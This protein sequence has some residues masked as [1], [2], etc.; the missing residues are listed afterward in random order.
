MKRLWTASFRS[1]VLAL[2]LSLAAGASGALAGQPTEDIRSLLD[3]VLGIL[4]NPALKTPAQKQHRLDL[5]EQAAARRFDYREMAKQ[6]LDTNWGSL[7][8]AQQKEFV[9]LFTA[10]LKASYAHRV[11]EIANARVAYLSE[12]Q[13]QDRAEVHTVILRP[14]DK[15]PVNFR[16]LREPDGWKIYD[17]VIE[18]V[19]LVK[20]FNHQFGCAIE[21]DSYDY[22]VRCL[23]GKLQEEK[24][25]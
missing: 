5:I 25:D 18:D 17:L 10:L 15:I 16:M 11:D 20:N 1:I 12:S 14:N 2:A 8:Q 24:G 19:S 4:H 9:Y 7:S 21:G 3:E 23:R 13:G 22:L 6:C